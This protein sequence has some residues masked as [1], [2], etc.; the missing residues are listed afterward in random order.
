MKKIILFLIISLSFINA[1]ALTYNGC[2]SSVIAKLKSMIKNINITYDYRIIDNQAYFDVTIN[3]LISDI[4]FYDTSTD[5]N[6]FYTDTNNGEI[7]IPNYTKSGIYRF[8]SNVV[9]C[10]GI[11]LG[12][13]YYNFPVYNRYY[14]HELCSDIPNFNLCKKWGYVNYSSEEFEKLIYDYK[15][16][17][18]SVLCESSLI[19][20]KNLFDKIAEF[21]I[22]YYY[23]ILSA[24]IIVGFV[25]IL[26]YN[27]KNSLKL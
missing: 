8:Y 17:K 19:Y 26:I 20:E 16:E 23:Y 21:Y 6:Y 5:R 24:I 18:S 2:D 4:Y 3:N 1:S 14:T 27:K 25:T 10:E 22:N 15:K 11:S 13:K 12:S 9:G 7:I